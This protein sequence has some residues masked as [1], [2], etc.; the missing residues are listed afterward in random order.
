MKNLRKSIPLVILFTSFMFLSENLLAAN[1]LTDVDIRNA[2]D[3]ELFFNATTPSYL[4]DVETY[5]GIVTL[6]GSVD[7]ILA[8]DMAVKI[9]KTVKG[10]RGVIDQIQVDAPYRANSILENNVKDALLVDP[11]TDS[12]EIT[13][14]A[15][16]GNV[17]LTGTV[18]SWQEKQLSEYVAKGVLGVKSIEN[19]ITVNYSTVRPDFEISEDIQQSLKNDIR[20]DDALIDVSVKKGKVTLS[21]TVGSANEKSLA[22]SKAW[23]AGVNSVDDKKLEVKEWARDKNLRKDKYVL[24]TDS[25]IK[26]AVEDAFLYDP[27]VFSFNPD[28][29]VK[30][31][32]VT[33]TGKVNN[34]KAKKAAEQNAKNVVG[35]LRVKNYLKVRPVFI[36]ADSD[37]EN[38]VESAMKKNPIIEKWEVDVTA[39][40]GVVYLNGSVD[41]YFE[42][43]T[44]EDL[45]SK[46]K[47]VIA[48]ENNLSV[49]D[50]NDY[51]FYN[52]YGWNTYYPPYHVDIAYTYDTDEVIKQNIIDELWWSPYVNQ[53][54][55]DVTVENGKAILEGTVDTKREK[56]YAEINAFEGGAIA[57]ENK[58]LVDFTL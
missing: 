22:Y 21:G 52:Y 32:V 2:V 10:V 35:V 55:V 46:I 13:V 50:D 57:V 17:R 29:S 5:E 16:N 43:S 11:A 45:A 40:N 44:A 54:E 58:I 23:T 31:G 25:E 48:V 12:Y 34:L 51:Y 14:T 27:R 49:F 41:S 30:T 36:P 37:L 56:V 6:S 7:N 3:K 20:I 26:E 33:L 42:K 38:Y 19:S 28:V 24:K 1:T 4:I 18:E 47:G 9:A 53:G 8:K 15:N 39:N